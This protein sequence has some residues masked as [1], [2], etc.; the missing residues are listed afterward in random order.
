MEEIEKEKMPVSVR[1]HEQ[2]AEQELPEKTQEPER[3]WEM[4]R[5]WHTY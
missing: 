5:R 2:K 3:Q 4:P 1:K